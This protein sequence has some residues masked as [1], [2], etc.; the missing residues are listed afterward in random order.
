MNEIVNEVRKSFYLDS[1]A[2][3]RL[4]AEI[5]ALGG[6]EEAVLMSGTPSNQQIMRDAGLLNDTGATA[7]AND[8]VIALRADGN[9]S[10][11]RALAQIEKSLQGQSKNSNAD[12]QQFVTLS[13]AITAKPEFNLALISTPGAYA[14]REAHTALDHGINAMIFS[15]NVS[16]EAEAS[17]KRKAQK[18][19]LLVM[20]PDCG[21][22]FIDSTPLAFANA[23]PAGNI[24]AI[25]ASGTGLQEFSVLLA[26]LGGG[27]RHG[28][29]VGG[30]DMH[31][32]VGAI[33]TLMAIDLL[34]ADEKTDKI[35]L[36]SKPPG[37]QSAKTVFDKLANCGKPAIV[38]MFGIASVPN[39][40]ITV[41]NTLAA[42]AEAAAG[43]SLPQSD[44]G[45][46]AA[47]LG[48]SLKPMQK[49]LKGLFTGGTLCTEAHL[50]L[51]GLGVAI[52]SNAVE[53]DTTTP[54]ALIDLGADEYTLGKPHP[55]L[56]PSVRSSHLMAELGKPETAVVMLDIV[57]GY[58]A[59]HDP[60]TEV[61]AVLKNIDHNAIVLA[62]VCGTP[63]D[64]QDYDQQCQILSEAGVVL[65]QCNSEMAT[66]AAAIV[67]AVSD[68]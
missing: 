3:M 64:P 47:E 56:E 7:N 38:C 66:L 22:A 53:S 43:N 35:I 15:D 39:N 2:L 48:N 23:I 49:H 4:S 12:T 20:G 27:I 54:H 28:I 62:S 29:G 51:R 18:L 50:V 55:M 45:K 25:A 9:A 1:V 32:D 8:L 58:G 31:D 17:L 67:N 34:A 26:K 21:T 11:N 52:E 36:I 13:S 30:R 19:D 63:D 6:I 42:A 40:D 10:V 57:L 61:S 68:Q 65:C 33:S 37:S 60:A 41:T 16:I 59:H 14:V 44:I 46:L 24:S 5:S